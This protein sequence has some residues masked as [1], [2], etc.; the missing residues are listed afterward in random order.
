MEN[1]GDKRSMKGTDRSSSV[2][3]GTTLWDR[4]SPDA[5]YQNSENLPQNMWSA[6][7]SERKHFRQWWRRSLPA[8]I[9][10]DVTLYIAI[11]YIIYFSLKYGFRD[12]DDGVWSYNRGEFENIVNY[13]R[14]NISLLSR[15]LTFLLGFYVSRIVARWWQ[16]FSA[17]PSPDILTAYCHAL[18]DLSSES[19][20]QWARRFMRYALLAYV[21]C[22]RRFS[23]ALEEQFP[24]SEAL[25]SA[26]LATRKELQ[27]LESE[28][29]LGRVWHVPISWAMIMIRRAKEAGVEV[30]EKKEMI[31][32]L[33]K[34]QLGLEK[35]D[36]YQHGQ[37]PPLYRQVVK[38]AVYSYFAVALFSEQ[39]VT[40]IPHIGVPIFLILKFIFF[41]GWLEV[42]KAIDDPWDGNDHEDFKIRELVSRHFWAVGRSLCQ[43]QIQP[44]T[45]EPVCPIHV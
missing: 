16:Q 8:N 17:L 1:M 10:K 34:F 19:G 21:L 7:W 32:T 28:A 25:F 37:L 12:K 45:L 42:A 6:F 36:S 13:F 26:G 41:F 27:L 2:E 22:L 15:D 3:D 39:E 4:G 24:D 35:I 33:S 9:W 29:D 44:I 11:Y 14:D 40:N 23:E 31:N 43:E 5:W 30:A 18:V 20:V 38:F